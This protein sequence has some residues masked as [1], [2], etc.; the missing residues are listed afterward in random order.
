MPDD[1]GLIDMKSSG[2]SMSPDRRPEYS[3]GL[4]IR[5]ENN[6]L[7]KLSMKRLPKVGDY[8]KIRAVVRV[9]SV[10]ESQTEGGRED[11]GV[12]LQIEKM[13]LK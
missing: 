8:Y 9:T 13:Q 11:R 12:Q 3:Y 1:D 7:E 2:K 6:E 10:N 4:N 5:L